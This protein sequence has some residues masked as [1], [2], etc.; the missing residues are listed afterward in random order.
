MDLHDHSWQVVSASTAA[1][2]FGAAGLVTVVV[3]GPL[4]VV[5]GHT[6]AEC[7]TLMHGVV[8][9]LVPR[10]LAIEE[11]DPSPPG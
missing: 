2:A 5:L 11:A 9:I 3:A 10:V 6:I 8:G 7:V 1:R 4:G